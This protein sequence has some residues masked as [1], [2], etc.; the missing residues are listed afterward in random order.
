MAFQKRLRALSWKCL[1]EDR[2]RVRQRQDKQGHLRRLSRQRDRR[3]PEVDLGL[4]RRMRQRQEDFL[5]PLLP[6]PH[7]VLHHRLAAGV[8][9]LIPQPLKDPVGRVPLPRWRGPIVFQDLLDHWQKRGQRPL[10]PGLVLPV[11]RRLIVRQDL[12]QRAPAQVVL[13]PRRPLA[14]LAGQNTLPDLFPKLHVGSHSSSLSAIR[15]YIGADAP[16]LPLRNSA[17]L[18]A[19]IFVRR[20]PRRPPPLSTAVNTRP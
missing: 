4:S 8:A 10:L 6:V 5:V 11:T 20:N 17:R 14:H 9:V 18:C 16:I 1:D 2:A 3:F 7:G 15:E 13:L 19:S 12:L